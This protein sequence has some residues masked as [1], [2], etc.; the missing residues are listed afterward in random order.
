MA[1]FRIRDILIRI[2]IL[3]SVHWITDPDPDTGTA[4]FG[5]GFQDTKKI[6]FF[7]VF[8][9]FIL[10]VQYVD[11]TSVFKDNMALISHNSRLENM[12]Y[13]NFFAC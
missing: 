11:V 13:L 4:H 6:V 3:G 9:C 8:F 2:R 10:A 1:V 12:V 5:N 7:Q